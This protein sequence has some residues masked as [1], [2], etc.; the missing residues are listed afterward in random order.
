LLNILVYGVAEKYDIA[1][2]K[3]EAK[4]QFEIRAEAGNLVSA[5]EFTEIITEIYRTTPSS[6]RGL[7]D[8][9]SQICA[10]HA[11]TIVNNTVFK[12]SIMETGEFVLDLLYEVL[13]VQSIATDEQSSEDRR[14]RNRIGA[15]TEEIGVQQRRLR[16]I[17]LTLV[18]S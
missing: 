12:S 9:V 3:D 18:W 6:D 10:R 13:K 5:S 16:D 14:L 11:Q 15:R 2:L 8:I 7:R 17:K 4:E 1:M